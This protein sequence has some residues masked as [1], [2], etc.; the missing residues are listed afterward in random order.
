LENI[1]FKVFILFFYFFFVSLRSNY[2]NNLNRYVKRLDGL[3]R[4]LNEKG[5]VLGRGGFFGSKSS[6]INMDKVRRMICTLAI[7]IEKR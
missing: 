5:A 7:L 1:Y 6:N 2:S 4:G 3:K